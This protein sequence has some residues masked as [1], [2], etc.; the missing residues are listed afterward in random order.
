VDLYDFGVTDD[1]A[2]YYVMEMLD[3]LDLATLVGRFGP[4]PAGRVVHLLRGACHSLGEAHGQGL[5]HRDV[6]PANIFTCRLG[7]DLDFVKVLD[8]GLVKS[9]GEEAGGATALTQE[10]S[11]AGTP[12]FMA[13]EMALGDGS[14]DGRADIYALGCVGY[15]LLTGQPVFAAD[16][17]VGT[18]LKH[19]Q[20]KPIPPS[21]RT[22]LEI[23]EELDSVILA[24]LAKDPADRPQT[25]EELDARLAACTVA[26][27]T[28]EMAAD[29]WKLHGSVLPSVR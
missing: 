24:C 14:V 16:T 8:F 2:F 11:V 19:V 29:W 17:P 7:P 13:P 10:G 3:G 15:W 23:P 20:E 1:G 4:L 21:R 5:I 6:K 12:A 25:A 9:T 26:A 18:L 28:H 27:W 22:E